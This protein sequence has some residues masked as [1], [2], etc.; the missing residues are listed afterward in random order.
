MMQRTIK[1]IVGVFQRL[2]EIYACSI[3][4]IIIITN[5]PGT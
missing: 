1:E 5:T 3:E 4:I 2:N